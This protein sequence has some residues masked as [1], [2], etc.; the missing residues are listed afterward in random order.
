MD[1]FIF[2]PNVIYEFTIN[3]DDQHQFV[4]KREARVNC[5]RSAIKDLADNFDEDTLYHLFP[6]VSMPQFGNTNKNRYARVHYHGIML[7]KTAQ[8]IR[9]FLT[10]NW[11]KL[12]GMSSIQFNPY[13]PDHWHTYCRKQKDM[14]KRQE[15]ICN[16]NWKTIEDAAT[17]P[18]EKVDCP[19]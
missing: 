16:T 9:R 2:S 5:V 14:F 15:R 4:N 8:S 3:P 1:K 6:E 10:T 7:F 11:H 13:R 12:T 17:S 18:S 19:E